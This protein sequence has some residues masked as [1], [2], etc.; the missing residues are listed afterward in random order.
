MKVAVIPAR[1]GS[2]RIK[3]K[4][5]KLFFS[6]PMIIW[7]IEKLKKSNFFDKIVV[8]SDSDDILNIVKKIKCTSTIKR[9][10]SLSG[11]HIGI[12]PVINHAIQKIRKNNSN[13]QYICCIYPCNPFLNI[14][15]LKK[16]FKK[17]KNNK[18]KFLFSIAQYSHPIQRAIKLK[19]NFCTSSYFRGFFNKR[20]QDLKKSYYDAG[21]FCWGTTKLWGKKINIHNS[22]VGFEVPFWRVVDID[23]VHDWKRAELLFKIL[24]KKFFKINKK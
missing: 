22:G 16:S 11:D 6:K 4:N 10:K 19:K 24:S 1:F 3:K 15:D 9:P 14:D 21:Q 17:F 5:I 18:K 2:K 12:Q 23:T 7:V 20:T 13:F 8:S